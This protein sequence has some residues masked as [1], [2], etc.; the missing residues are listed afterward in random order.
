MVMDPKDNPFLGTDAMRE[1]A[2][3]ISNLR[4]IRENLIDSHLNNPTPDELRSLGEMMV[5]LRRREL[6]ILDGAA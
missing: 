5:S 3:R 6:M 4:A 1:R 2:H